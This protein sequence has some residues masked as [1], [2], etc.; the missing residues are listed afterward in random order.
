MMFFFKKSLKKFLSVIATDE[1]VLLPTN[2]T[3]LKTV[4]EK[5]KFNLYMRVVNPL[6]CHACTLYLLW[7]LVIYL[8][9]C[10]FLKVSIWI[11][12]WLVI[13]V[14]DYT[15]LRWLKYHP[16]PTQYDFALLSRGGVNLFPL[17]RSWLYDLLRPNRMQWKYSW[18]TSKANQERWSSLY[19]V[20]LGG[21]QLR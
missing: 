14:A 13:D 20:P 6:D 19:L 9:L 1:W 18:V 16:Q 4:R 10:A 17:N 15:F 12:R 21:S 3:K 5:G 7:I 11:I 2:N 8:A